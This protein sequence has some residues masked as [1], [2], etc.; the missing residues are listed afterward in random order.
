MT[1]RKKQDVTEIRKYY[2][3]ETKSKFMLGF[4]IQLI[5]GS[6]IHVNSQLSLIQLRGRAYIT[7]GPGCFTWMLSVDADRTQVSA[8]SAQPCT[9]LLESSIAADTFG[10][11]LAR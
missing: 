8:R 3:L 1:L 5:P 6:A 10:H 9:R 2:S 4:T 11:L 7:S